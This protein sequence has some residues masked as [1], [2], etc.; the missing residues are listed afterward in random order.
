MDGPDSEPPSAVPPELS[1]GAALSS[2]I[3]PQPSVEP[4]PNPPTVDPPTAPPHSHAPP[5]DPLNPVV[6]PASPLATPVGPIAAP[7]V[8]PV[9]A[10]AAPAAAPAVPIY[11]P[12]REFRNNHNGKCRSCVCGVAAM[13]RWK[14]EMIHTHMKAKAKGGGNQHLEEGMWEPVPEWQVEPNPERNP[15]LNLNPNPI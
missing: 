1:L 12:Q 8:A 6:V 7:D 3:S 14:N 9:A 4:Y 2:P 13:L 11:C 5:L 15:S 10:L